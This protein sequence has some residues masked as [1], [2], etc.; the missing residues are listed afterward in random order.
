MPPLAVYW[1]GPDGTGPDGICGTPDIG[2]PGAPAAYACGDPP[3]YG[4]V[5][6]DE[7]GAYG[8]GAPDDGP[9]G[10]GAYGDGA[11]DDTAPDG[12]PWFGCVGPDRLGA[13]GDGAPDDGP[14]GAGAYGDD[15]A[16]DDGGFVATG[17]CSFVDG[18]G[19]YGAGG[20]FVPGFGAYGEVTGAC[21]GRAGERW[22][23]VG[24]GRVVRRVGNGTPASVVGGAGPSG[25][26]PDGGSPPSEDMRAS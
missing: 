18:A 11:P 6:P 14:L 5:G 2:P 19:A 7:G 25:G 10:C 22:L 9:L 13:Y 26:L 1:L 8:D 20:G 24:G 3:G 21:D 15:G 16:P 17:F 12:G 4:C 23:V